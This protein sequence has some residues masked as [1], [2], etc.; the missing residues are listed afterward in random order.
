MI[1]L[2]LVDTCDGALP[3]RLPWIW[4]ASLICAQILRMRSAFQLRLTS[5]KSFKFSSSSH[6][7]TQTYDDADHQRP[8]HNV[9]ETLGL[10]REDCH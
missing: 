10:E 2:S 3:V 9:C 4:P 8:P 5:W 1:V 7:Q 6:S